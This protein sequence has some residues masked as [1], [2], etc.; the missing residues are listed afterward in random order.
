MKK[1]K[2]KIK[3]TLSEISQAKYVDAWDN[4]CEKY[5]YDFYCINEG[6]DADIEVEITLQD[7]ENWGL[8]DED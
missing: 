1:S 6:A 2:I 5:R 4:F 7:A 3:T 8:I